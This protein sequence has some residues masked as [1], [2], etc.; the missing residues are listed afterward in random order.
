MKPTLALLLLVACNDV[1][2]VAEDAA[3]TPDAGSA[4]APAQ[5]PDAPVA[6]ACDPAWEPLSTIDGLATFVVGV[7]SRE[8][9]DQVAIAATD[10]LRILS[11]GPDDSIAPLTSLAP[12]AESGA[13]G[14]TAVWMDVTAI[15]SGFAALGRSNQEPYP[16]W[17]SI[18][19][20]DASGITLRER[21][22][23]DPMVEAF[24][25]DDRTVVV[26]GGEK[27]WFY[28]RGETGVFSQTSVRDIAGEHGLLPAVVLDG[29]LAIVSSW[30]EGVF[31]VPRDGAQPV[32]QIRTTS[33]PERAFLTDRG[34]V[35]PQSSNFWS[36]TPGSLSVLDLETRSLGFLSSAPVISAADGED[37]PFHGVVYQGLLFVANGESGLLT[38][39]WDETVQVPMD[40][41]Y[42]VELWP[43]FSSHPQRVA[44]VRD[45]LFISPGQQA[46]GVARLCP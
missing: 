15:P 4:D 46:V 36:A 9:P 25:A 29:E 31:L 7:A 13:T 16:R 33:H 43:G 38:T 14:G 28:Q 27:I 35:V 10:E 37:G 32:T 20:L 42:L 19:T 6:A 1:T 5:P 8:S 21:I 30:L 34:W 40:T 12:L 39:E 2:T 11:V 41:E 17:V 24:A 44:R 22:V 18:Y 3:G 45:L 26:V 23:V